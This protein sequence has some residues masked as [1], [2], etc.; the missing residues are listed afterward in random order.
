M[1]ISLVVISESDKGISYN[2][3]CGK[4]TIGRNGKGCIVDISLDKDT[5]ISR[6]AQAIVIYEPKKRKFLIQASNGNSLIYL[7]DD[8]LMNFSDLSAYDKI[9][10]GNTELMFMPFCSDRFSWE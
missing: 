8:L 10:I 3:K 7:N 5:S 9:T 6:G 2:L 4:N 1:T